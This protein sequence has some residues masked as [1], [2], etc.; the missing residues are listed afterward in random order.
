MKEVHGKVQGL[1]ASQLRRLE[2]LQQRSGS[3]KALCEP[4]L[5]RALTECCV[6]LGRMVGLL[7]DRRGGVSDVVVGEPTRLYLPDIGR[8]RA[9]PGR[10]RGLRLVVARPQYKDP[11]RPWTVDLDLI[12]DLERLQLDAVCEIEAK[13]GG[14]D[15]G[16]PGRVAV[17]MLLPNAETRTRIDHWRSIH[18]VDVDF[19]ATVAALEEELAKTVDRRRSTDLVSERDVAVLVGVY[20]LPTR[21]E[22]DERMAELRE[23]AKTAG[24]RVVDEV[25]QYRRLTGFAPPAHEQYVVGKGRLEEICLS[26]LHKGAEMIIFD[27][28][29]TPSQ[30]NSITDVTDMKIVDRTMLIL[31]IFARRAK[32]REGRMQVELAQLRYSVPRL[33][34]KQ[35]G[36][37]RL[38]GGIGG[39]GPGETKLEVDRRRAKDKITRLEREIDQFSKDRQLRRR[40]RDE[41]QVPI[42]AIVGYTNAG[43]STL[44]NRLTGADVYV[45]DELFATLDTTSRRLRFPL[46][47]EVVLT[48]T[49][50]FIRDLP[51]PLVNAF[52]ATL[53]ELHEADLLLHV[54]DGNDALRQ[55][56]VDA[57]CSV[58]EELG[59][60][61]TPRLLV[62]NK[63]DAP[64]DDD[65]EARRWGA[66]RVSG[67]TGE[68]L[69]HLVNKMAELLWQ[70]DVVE[71]QEQWAVSIPEGDAEGGHASAA[72]PFPADARSY[73]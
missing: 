49:V 45:A 14:D 1:R 11:K 65:A 19:G 16:L 48:D 58:L 28:E 10:L 42:I 68:G 73:R 26:A 17:A 21:P 7:L 66:V 47:R 9:G 18:D 32:S 23:L 35:E 6:D 38:T 3:S 36:L 27:G 67:L 62:L 61:S 46:E 37:S 70:E 25:V 20:H 30:M 64:V 33:A 57:V 54:V 22:A 56:H 4:A 71:R 34:K 43:K 8:L 15:D 13:E 5:A 29:L 60:L 40:R 52:R 44:L 51:T 41:R 12:T 69:P 63:G 2:R 59:L 31:D 50:G 72:E 24:V 55:K 39:Q 53:E